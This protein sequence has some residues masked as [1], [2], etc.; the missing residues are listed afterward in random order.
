MQQGKHTDYERTLHEEMLASLANQEDSETTEQR[1]E[2]NNDNGTK[3][4]GWPNLMRNS[5]SDLPE[6][7]SRWADL[8]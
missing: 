4:A 7:S 2:Q 3:D 1:N 8:F 6:M 5:Y